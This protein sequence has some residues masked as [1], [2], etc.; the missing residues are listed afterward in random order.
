MRQEREKIDNNKKN[1]NNS[2]TTQVKHTAKRRTNERV[3][4]QRIP[5]ISMSI[6]AQR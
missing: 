5:K 3:H 4:E 2:I 6:I 1:K